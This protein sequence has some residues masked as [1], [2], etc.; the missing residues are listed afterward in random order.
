MA[1]SLDWECL[2]VNARQ[3]IQILEQEGWFKDLG[4]RHVVMIK[5]G[6]RVPIPVHGAKD[7]KSY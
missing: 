4:G 3:I 1:L 6:R 5:N 7:I 2:F